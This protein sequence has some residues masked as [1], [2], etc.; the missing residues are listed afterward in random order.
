M[1]QYKV[2]L[3]VKEFSFLEV[4]AENCPQSFDL[5]SS[6]VKKIRI[7]KGGALV[8]DS[9]GGT[10]EWGGECNPNINFSVYFAVREKGCDPEE[11]TPIWGIT[12]LDSRGQYD[13]PQYWSSWDAPSNGEQLFTEGL[14]PEFIVLVGRE[15]KVCGNGEISISITIYK[16]KDFDLVSYH[17]CQIDRAAAELKAEI[18]ATCRA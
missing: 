6:E 17:Q 8:M 2:A 10:D 18:A 13:S 16:M 1:K 12:P 7:E 4:I 14:E 15:G 3:L 9:C 5:W 11:G